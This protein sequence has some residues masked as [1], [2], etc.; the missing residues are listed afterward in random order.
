V[1]WEKVADR[2]DEGLFA[3]VVFLRTEKSGQP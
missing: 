3:P 2:P 1:T